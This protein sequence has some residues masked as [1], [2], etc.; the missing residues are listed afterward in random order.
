[1]NRFAKKLGFDFKLLNVENYVCGYIDRF[2]ENVKA[3]IGKLR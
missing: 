2:N 1:M 3:M